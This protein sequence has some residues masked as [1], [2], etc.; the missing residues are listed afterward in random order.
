MH[1]P[2]RGAAVRKGSNAQ[3][4]TPFFRPCL[5]C[6]AVQI[7]DCRDAASPPNPHEEA[8]SECVMI[9]YGLLPDCQTHFQLRV[10]YDPPHVGGGRGSGTAITETSK[11]QDARR[12][13][14]CYERDPDARR[15]DQGKD[16]RGGYRCGGWISATDSG[17]LWFLVPGRVRVCCPPS[18]WQYGI[19]GF[20]TMRCVCIYIWY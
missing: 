18:L 11:A 16:T 17:T 12:C 7:T 6:V 1:T 2:K 4:F 15:G 19:D 5:T 20:W 3:V 14:C 9:D 8:V 13:R 10:K